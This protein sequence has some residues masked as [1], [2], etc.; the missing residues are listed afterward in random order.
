VRELRLWL[1]IAIGVGL[2]VGVATNVIPYL[3]CEPP[4]A[5]PIRVLI[6]DNSLNRPFYQPVQQWKR[7]LN[8]VPVDAVHMPSGQQV[9]S[10]DDYTHVIITG[11][12]ASLVDPPPPDWAKEEAELVKQAADRGLAI[13]G[14]CFGHQM[15][16]FALSGPE[17]IRRAALP[18]V[19]WV[20]VEMSEDDPLFADLP[21]PWH[22]FA[23]HYDEVVDPP[24]PAWK[25][26]GSTSICDVAVIRYG[27]APIWGLQLHPE[28]TPCDAKSL[29]LLQRLFRDWKSKE[30]A[31]ALRQK[32]QDDKIIGVIVERF[33]AARPTR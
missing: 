23:W 13:L 11:S 27:D 32:P 19:G 17:H 25:V 14:S 20:A 2:A 1:L 9:S 18:E 31:A 10:L 33:L 15:L 30:I 22:A 26:L 8:G 7:Y 3:Q 29:L 5:S 6:L 4:E 28:T 12:T 21:N 24:S 16:A